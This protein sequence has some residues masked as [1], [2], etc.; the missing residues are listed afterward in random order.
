MLEIKKRATTG[1]H[2]QLYASELEQVD[3]WRRVQPKIPSMSAA[4]RTLIIR[5]LEASSDVPPAK[6]TAA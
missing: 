1:V 3:R 6:D 2:S 4:F 5:G